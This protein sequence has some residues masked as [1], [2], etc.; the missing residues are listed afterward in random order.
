MST[1][2]TT[3]DAPK[4]PAQ[5]GHR[6]GHA[7]HHPPKKKRGPVFRI[8]AIAV[9]AGGCYWL[10]NFIHR[11]L[12]FEETDDAYIAGHVHIISPRL[13][14]SV[15]EVLVDENEVVKKGQVLA[16]LDS[17]ACEIALQRSQAALAAAKAGVLQAATAVDQAKAEHAQCQAQTVAAA[18]QVQQAEAQARLAN[19]NRDR[20]GRL[21]S[22][23]TRTVSKADVDTTHSAAEA[24][25]AGQAAARAASASAQARVKVSAAAVA[26][27]EAAVVSARAKL[28]GEEAAVRDAERQ[29]AYCAIPSPGDGRIGNK[30]IEVGNRVQV[31]QAVF[32]LVDSDYWIVANFKETQMQKLHAGAP[33]EITVDALGGRQFVG[34]IESIAPATGAQFALL[35]PDN[36][37]G[38]FTKVVQRV[39][40]KV[41]F[42][43]ASVR[44]FEDRLRPGLSTVV[45]VRIK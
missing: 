11:A 4:P 2:A 42:D 12:V 23:D 9:L 32:A 44:G 15:T 3:T 21:F 17:Q 29:L 7:T 27:A 19:I 10:T 13:S 33:V 35:P 38:N 25:E 8:F 45:S 28:E 14:E 22:A 36:A 18:A 26:S 6:A 41:L 20:A 34:K 39:P 43:P 16:R 24:A 31:G 1:N 5:H 40:V 30:N 37:T